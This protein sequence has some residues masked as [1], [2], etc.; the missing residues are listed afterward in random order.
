MSPLSFDNGWT[1]RNVDY[2]INAVDE[3]NC[4]GYKFGEL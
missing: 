3:K 4:Y 2:C 1:D